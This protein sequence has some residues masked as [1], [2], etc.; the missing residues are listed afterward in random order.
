MRNESQEG[1]L[2]PSL[3]MSRVVRLQERIGADAIADIYDRKGKLLAV[4][5]IMFPGF[6]AVK[7]ADDLYLPSSW[8]MN[9]HIN[10]KI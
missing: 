1:S 8:V 3:L 10:G 2:V 4:H 7:V 9:Q 6:D 5:G